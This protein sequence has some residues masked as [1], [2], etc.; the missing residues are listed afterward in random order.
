MTGRLES[1]ADR[2]MAAGDAAAAA[3]RHMA[4]AHGRARLQPAPPA[5][6]PGAVRHLWGWF[7]MLAA[8]YTPD[9]TAEPPGPGQLA[10]DLTALTGVTPR[11]WE[12]QCVNRLLR[13][14][15]RAGGETARDGNRPQIHQLPQHLLRENDH[16]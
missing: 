3:L 6:P 9:R 4:R 16:D 13:R 12:L 14:W 1:W 7:V 15:L 11:D 5:G 10:G 8:F 2:Q